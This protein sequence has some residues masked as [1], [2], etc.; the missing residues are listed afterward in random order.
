MSNFHDRRLPYAPA[1]SRAEPDWD[2][3]SDQD[4]EDLTYERAYHHPET[5]KVTRYAPTPA[6]TS[7]EDED[8]NHWSERTYGHSPA[9]TAH[10]KSQGHS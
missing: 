5:G 1:G 10:T 6:N 7:V 9:L 3:L 8:W 4:H 2:S